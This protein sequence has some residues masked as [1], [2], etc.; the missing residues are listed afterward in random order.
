MDEAAKRVFV[1]LSVFANTGFLGIPIL[2]ALYGNEG[3]LYAV[4]YNLA[5]QIFFFSFGVT[6]LS[7]RTEHVIEAVVK[8][9][10]T[11]ASIFAII[12]FLSPFRFPSFLAET[13]DMVGGMMVPVSMMIIGCKLANIKLIDILTDKYSYLVSVLRL[14]VFPLV[15]LLLLRLLKLDSILIACM[16]V[17]TGLPSGTLNVIMADKYQCDPEYAA[18]A[19]SQSTLLLIVGLPL[20]QYLLN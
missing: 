2:S 15:M 3:V 11:I 13:M 1:T 16:V 9:S 8:D 12:I 4:I 18:R 10:G 7:G 19:V 5:Y 17:L 6:I 20:L 14:I